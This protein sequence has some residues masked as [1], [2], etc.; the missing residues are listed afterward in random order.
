MDS[1]NDSEFYIK[2]FVCESCDFKCSKKGDFNRHL[3]TGKH[4]RCKN[5]SNDAI[6]PLWICGCGKQYK[7]DSGYYRHK[8]SCELGENTIIEQND[9]LD[10]KDMFLT[11]MN[12]N[13]ELR[14]SLMELI[15]KIGNNNTNTTNTNTNN[16]NQK[17]NINVF[18]NEQCKDAIN[19][20]DF[21]KSIEVSLE[22]LDVSKTKGLAAGLSKIII[23]NLNE[24]GVHERPIH[25]TDLKREMLFVRDKNTW[26]R[27]KN[28][29]QIK[30]AIKGAAGKQYK[31]VQTWLRENP[32]YMQ[33]EA[34]QDYFARTLSAIGKDTKTIDDKVIRNLCNQTY[35]KDVE[36]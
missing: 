33:D 13:Q 19:I 8:K 18:L 5:D 15:P 30:Q 16:V 32:N 34:K 10:Y 29:V 11:M 26:A 25:C 31:A 7:Y 2:Q 4:K 28:N 17:F 20:T 21:I 35:V 6:T 24:L 27:D 22:Q 23:E 12:E 36:L 14:K 1:K 9:T 3:L